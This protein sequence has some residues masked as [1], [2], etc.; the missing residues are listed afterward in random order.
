MQA[1]ADAEAAT[2]GNQPPA[3]RQSAGFSFVPGA[4]IISDLK[5]RR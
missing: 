1:R 5:G 4:G 2:G 3:G